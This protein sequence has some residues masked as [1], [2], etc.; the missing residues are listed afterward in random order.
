[1][2]CAYVLVL[3]LTS[4]TTTSE[5]HLYWFSQTD[6]HGGVLLRT[7]PPG[8]HKELK[9]QLFE[10]G[11]WPLPTLGADL[12]VHSLILREDEPPLEDQIYDSFGITIP[13]IQFHNITGRGA[14]QPKSNKTADIIPP[15]N[16]EHEMGD[17]SS[18]DDE[19]DWNDDDSTETTPEDQKDKRRNTFKLEFADDQGSATEHHPYIVTR[20]D[21]F[22]FV[23]SK[24]SLTHFRRTHLRVA[25]ETKLFKRQAYEKAQKEVA[26][27]SVRTRK[28]FFLYKNCLLVHATVVLTSG[29][30]YHTRISTVE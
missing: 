13:L 22:F 3:G 2:N 21:S 1:M 30:Q 16:V 20:F 11:L 5:H 10:N 27:R 18:E 24:V 17:T 26:N 9:Y 19:S 12:V 29:I 25:E 7:I 23:R 15:E 28:F 6:L 4:R 14:V 8:G